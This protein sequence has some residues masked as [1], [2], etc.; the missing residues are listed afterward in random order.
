MPRRT[1]PRLSA[2]TFTLVVLFVCVAGCSAPAE[3]EPTPPPTAETPTP[4]P[5]PSPSETEPPTG[6]PFEVS[7]T[8]E[9]THNADGTLSVTAE[10]NLP[11]GADLMASLRTPDGSMAQDRAFL[12]SGRVEFGP[13]SDH[14]GR[15]PSGS[16]ELSISMSTARLQSATVRQYIGETGELMTGPLVVPDTIEG[17]YWVN[18][19][20]IVTIS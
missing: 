18:L 14:G 12:D 20:S 9:A 7:I 5:T 8:F 10:S 3:P 17:G 15:L 16:Y 2:A 19:T 11:D 13:F 1:L 4:T 6:A